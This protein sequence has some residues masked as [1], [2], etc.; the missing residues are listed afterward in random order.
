MDDTRFATAVSRARDL[1][2]PELKADMAK[3]GMKMLDRVSDG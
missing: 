3:R 2:D 1:V